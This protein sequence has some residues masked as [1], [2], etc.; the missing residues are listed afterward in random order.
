MS[1]NKLLLTLPRRGEIASLKLGRRAR[2]VT[3]TELER[4][5]AKLQAEQA[6]DAVTH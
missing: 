5:V 3:V 1:D 4:Y 6:G 2:R